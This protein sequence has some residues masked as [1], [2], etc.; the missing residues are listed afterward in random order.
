MPHK[1]GDLGSFIDEWTQ[2]LRS[3]GKSQ[4]TVEKY[5]ESMVQFIVFLRQHGMPEQV[6]S[7][8]REHVEA[9]IVDLIERHS[10]GTAVTRFQSLRQMFNYLVEEGEAGTHPMV[11][12]RPPKPT[13]KLIQPV[14]AD[15]L[16]TLVKDCG[17]DFDGRRDE[18]IIRLFADSGLRLSELTNIEWTDIDWEPDGGVVLIPRGKGDRPREVRFGN[19]TALALRKYLRMRDG[20]RRA[21]ETTRLFITS[22]GPIT[23]SGVR[24]MIWKRCT[25]AFGPE[26]RIH[27]HQL[28]HTFA[29]DWLAAGGEEGD[30]MRMTGWKTR[31]MVD[32]YAKATQDARA[33]E[34]H[35]RLRLGDRF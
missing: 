15:G 25:A 24:Q 22:K 23:P 29:H 31:A 35:R 6:G 28:R 18:A 5:L 1:L 26:G 33:K 13:E 7:I 11:N 4:R 19:N 34:A 9:F 12:M 2:A 30:L 20:H 14:P 27:P 17:R 10:K 21:K 8:R 3:E 16:R 32:R